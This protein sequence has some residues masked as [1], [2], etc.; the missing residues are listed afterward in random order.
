[1][2]AVSE[3]LNDQLVRHSD[4][5]YYLPILQKA[6]ANQVP[7]PD[8]CIETS[9][10]LLEGVSKTIIERLDSTR[11]RAD[12]DAKELSPLVKEA[13]R[14]L[15]ANDDQFEMD[16]TNRCVSLAYALGQ[17]RNA[18]GDISHGRAVPKQY[19]SSSDLA[20]F[21][22]HMTE[23]VLLY[24]L[25]SFYSVHTGD[26]PAIEYDDNQDFNDFLDELYPMEGKPLYSLA[27]FEQY[28]EDYEIQLSDFRD[29]DDED[30][31]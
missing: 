14:L 30:D 23:G 9:K 31:E 8:I 16:F 2:R 1:M 12:L 22:M 20:R 13:V 4:F 24:M 28:K 18:R 10:S 25:Q 7:H 19:C 21:V 15:Q 29:S 5:A 6:E 11:S 3:L 26:E 17:L 27:L